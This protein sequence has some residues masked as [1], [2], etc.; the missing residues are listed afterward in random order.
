[1]EE[2]SACL[3]FL[4]IYLN[5]L[6]LFSLRGYDLCSALRAAIAFSSQGVIQSLLKLLK[7][8]ALY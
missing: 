8:A 4:A 6:T 5:L 1:L 3:Q 2:R 7:V